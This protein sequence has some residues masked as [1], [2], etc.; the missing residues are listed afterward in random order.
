MPKHSFDI[1]DFVPG[2]SIPP[3]AGHIFVPIRVVNRQSGNSR[4][5]YALLDTGAASCVFPASLAIGTGHRLKGDG[6][7]SSLICGIEQRSIPSYLHAFVIELFSPDGQRVVWRSPEVPV[8]CVEHEVS[9]ILGFKEFLSQF[10]ELT[11]AYPANK[12]SL[13][14]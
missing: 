2:N 1:I 5:T 9:P 13:S 7:N 3:P 12:F 11:V 14:W 4:L 6:V 10:K 8:H